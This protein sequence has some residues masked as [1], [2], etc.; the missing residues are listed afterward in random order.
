MDIVYIIGTNSFY[1]KLKSRLFIYKNIFNRII[2]MEPNIFRS[3]S[4]GV[5]LWNTE[6]SAYVIY[7][8][9]LTIIKLHTPWLDV[10]SVLSINDSFRIYHSFEVIKQ[11]RSILKADFVKADFIR[12]HYSKQANSK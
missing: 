2:D 4:N 11:S 5:A 8:N 12:Y 7:E 1:S 10:N 9:N 6:W 3:E